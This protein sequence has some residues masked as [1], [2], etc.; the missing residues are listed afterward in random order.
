MWPDWRMVH[1][2]TTWHAL[3]GLSMR[4][5]IVHG[6]FSGGCPSLDVTPCRH[7]R[8]LICRSDQ[9]SSVE[10]QQQPSWPASPSSLLNSLVGSQA[11]WPPQ[12]TQHSQP[13]PHPFATQQVHRDRTCVGALRCEK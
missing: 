12:G 11:R 2:D 1:L 7:A 3:Y 4:R 8:T 9:H 5:S 13:P 6:L 10:P